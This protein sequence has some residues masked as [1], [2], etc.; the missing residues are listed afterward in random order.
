[1]VAYRLV[2]K[3]RLACA[4]AC[5]VVLTCMPSSILLT[6]TPLLQHLNYTCMVAYYTEGGG[7]EFT[8]KLP[9]LPTNTVVSIQG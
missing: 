4:H 5:M 8:E 1:M 2:Y 6:Y 7:M 3:A 9:E